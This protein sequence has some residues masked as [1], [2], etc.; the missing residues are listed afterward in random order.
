MMGGDGTFDEPLREAWHA[1]YGTGSKSDEGH[2]EWSTVANLA[3]L[4]RLVLIPRC[5]PWL[6]FRA[7]DNWKRV[8]IQLARL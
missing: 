2:H 7:A 4:C 8:R 3:R 1:K 5:G 6:L